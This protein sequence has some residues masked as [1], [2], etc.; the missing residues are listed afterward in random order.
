VRGHEFPCRA[1]TEELYEKRKAESSGAWSVARGWTWQ[2]R[3][4]RGGAERV[5]GVG[6]RAGRIALA[7]GTAGEQAATAMDNAA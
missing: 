3:G 4:P 1:G 6:G 2:K 7:D 5:V